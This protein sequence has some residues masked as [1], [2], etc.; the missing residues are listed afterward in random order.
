[1]RE[2]GRL[3]PALR[4]EHLESL[5]AIVAAERNAVADVNKV[6]SSAAWGIACLYYQVV[7]DK[8]ESLH[9][10]GVHPWLRYV[11]EKGLAYTILVDGAPLRT[12]PPG[13]EIRDVMDGEWIAIREQTSLFAEGGNPN[14]ILRL[15]VSQ[16]AGMPVRSATLF[17]YDK[18]TGIEL[19]S[20]QLY[21]SDVTV[22]RDGQTA[23]IL[24][25]TRRAQDIDATQ[26]F[27]FPSEI[28][29]TDGDHGDR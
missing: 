21:N 28:K 3:Y 17:L 10:S 15:V 18:H 20:V 26:R 24:P 16:R 5:A 8:L 27:Q 6:F 14:A 12:Q 23:E 22:T 9:D 2:I 4:R 25:L 1:M 29:K 11:K 19:D 7:K 13:D